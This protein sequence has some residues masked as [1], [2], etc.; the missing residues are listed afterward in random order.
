MLEEI[1][2]KD[3][4]EKEKLEYLI[5]TKKWNPYCLRHSSISSDSD[6]LP[7]YALKKKVRWSM[8]SKQ[9]TRYIKTR[10]GNDLKE[11]ILHYNGITSESEI[12]KKPSIIDCPRCQ[13]V[14]AFE[15]KYCSKCSYPLKPEA[16]EEIKS[17]EDKR[18]KILEE[19]QKQKDEQI[20]QLIAKQ[21]KFEKMIQSLIDIGQLKPLSHN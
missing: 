17:E 7:E 3:V 9:G 4:K 18:M 5:K 8:N 15:N 21:E 20:N 10:L 16:Y 12:K 2:I 19:K 6:F 11:K 13:V 14:N 1:T